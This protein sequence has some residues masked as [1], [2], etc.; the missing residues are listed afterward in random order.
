MARMKRSRMQKV[1]V[2][3]FAE[4]VDAIKELAREEKSLEWHP[5]LRQ[6]VSLGLEAA[7]KRRIIK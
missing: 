7:R 6:I 2:L 3:L 1:N 5:K 4:D